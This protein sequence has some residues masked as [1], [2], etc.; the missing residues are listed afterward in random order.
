MKYEYLRLHHP[1]DESSAITAK[2]NEFGEDGWELIDINIH[3][4]QIRKDEEIALERWTFKR[5][6]KIPLTYKPGDKF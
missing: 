3:T 4:I 1:T 6:K 5:L 2:L